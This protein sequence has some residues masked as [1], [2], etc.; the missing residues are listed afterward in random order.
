MKLSLKIILTMI[1]TSILLTSCLN[2]FFKDEKETNTTTSKT[3]NTDFD[4]NKLPIND[5]LKPIKIEKEDFVYYDEKDGKII[6]Y[7]S[8][9]GSK[10]LWIK[11][12]GRVYQILQNYNLNKELK[13]PF[14]KIETENKVFVIGNDLKV[15]KVINR[16]K[17]PEQGERLNQIRNIRTKIIEFQKTN[18]QIF[19]GTGTFEFNGKQYN[20]QEFL[21]FQDKIISAEMKLSNPSLLYTE[22]GEDKENPLIGKSIMEIQEFKDLF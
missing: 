3:L 15:K 20:K 17:N 21:E 8:E 13:E 9:S 7:I 22:T 18:P 6:G 14:N 1:L 10:K 5:L 12:G 2:S 11:H 4:V 16:T 19:L